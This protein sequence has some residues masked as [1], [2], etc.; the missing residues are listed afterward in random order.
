MRDILWWEAGFIK[1]EA[2]TAARPS[3]RVQWGPWLLST[4]LC[5]L[6]G[7]CIS[8]S[9]AALTATSGRLQLPDGRAW[10]IVSPPF[11]RGAKVEPIP[12]AGGVIQAADGGEAITYIANA[13]MGGGIQGNP[14][15]NYTQVLSTRGV[16]GG[17]SALD[18]ATTQNSAT[19]VVPGHPT[20]YPFFSSDL[21]R[22]V[23]APGLGQE[24]TTPLPP[25]SEGAEKTIYI[26]QADGSYVPLVTST[27]ATSGEKFGSELTFTGATPDLS[28]VLLK[29]GVPLTD[30]PEVEGEG[31]YEWSAGVLRPVSVLPGGT[32]SGSAKLGNKGIDTRNA[33]SED[34][35]RVFWAE[36]FGAQDLFMRQMTNSETVEIN[37]TESGVTGG[38]VEVGTCLQ[39]PV[40]QLANGGGSEAFFTDEARLTSNST[41]E[42]E[43][44]DLYMFEVT[45]DAP[46]AGKLTDLTADQGQPADVQGTLIGAGEEA[47]SKQITSLYFVAGGVL[48]ENENE[49]HEKAATGADNLYVMRRV[50]AGWATTFIAGLTGDDVND[51]A[52]KGF[53]LGEMTARVSP[54]GEYLAFMSDKSL[55]GYDNRDAKSGEPDEEV[56]LYHAATASLVCASCDPTGARP[57]GVYDPVSGPQNNFGTLIVDNP[58]NWSGRWLAGSIPGWTMSERGVAHY[59]SRYLSDSGRLFFDSPDTLVPQ[60]TNGLENVFEYEPAEV[61]SCTG[62]ASTFNDASHGCVAL[63]SSGT[64]GGESAFVDASQSGDDVFFVTN[65]RLVAQDEDGTY[66]VYNAHVC[67]SAAPCLP[68]AATAPPVCTTAES[69]RHTVN[70]QPQVF[71]PPPS[72]TF[73]GADNPSPPSVKKVTHKKKAKP[74]KKRAKRRRDHGRSKRHSRAGVSKSNKR[75]S[76]RTGR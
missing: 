53:G 56:F 42:S 75:S 39:G 70:D 65:G 44:P 12:P 33:I 5:C 50:G 76:G 17:W 21:S 13:P 46:L 73:D 51:W 57:L 37:N 24:G 47:G 26:R 4:A 23:V 43:A 16:G 35:S 60:A 40:F 71:G 32:A 72:A 61:G 27:N 25:L 7:C 18:I 64:S 59:Q 8:S 2:V 55:T 19:G 36:S 66:D 68:V 6:A 30:G 1:R 28:Y 41:A 69:C 67:S 48:A 31:L 14:G 9:A 49:A 63:I 29:S 38:C 3:R 54:N 52:E 10:E 74:K 34:G 11:K 15:P 45:N 22:S 62:G 58:E 20:E